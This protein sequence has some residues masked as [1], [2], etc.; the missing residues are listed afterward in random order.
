MDDTSGRARGDAA[1]EAAE[2]TAAVAAMLEDAAQKGWVP[3]ERDAVDYIAPEDARIVERVDGGHPWARYTARLK[4]G[5]LYQEGG[6]R[7]VLWTTEAAA[8]KLLQEKARAATREAR[9]FTLLE[10]WRLARAT[11]GVGLTV[12]A[13]L[14]SDDALRKALAD[15]IRARAADPDQAGTVR[16]SDHQEI[17]AELGVSDEDRR[18]LRADRSVTAAERAAAAGDEGSARNGDVLAAALAAARGRKDAVVLEGASAPFVGREDSAAEQVVERPGPEWSYAVVLKGGDLHFEGGLRRERHTTARTAEK[19]VAARV[20]ELL[21]ARDLRLLVWL[22]RQLSRARGDWAAEARIAADPKLRERLDEAIR[23]AAADYHA[24]PPL[25]VAQAR[26]LREAGVD[27]D[28]I[29]RLAAPDARAAVRSAAARAAAIARTAW[30][31]RT[32]TTVAAAVTER[33]AA[34]FRW[35]AEDVVA[36]VDPDDERITQR[37]AGRPDWCTHAVVLDDGSVHLEGGVVRQRLAPEDA[38]AG[39]FAAAAD[40]LLERGSL[41]ALLDLQAAIDASPRPRTLA[42]FVKGDAKRQKLLRA[43]AQA[44]AAEERYA[45]HVVRPVHGAALVALGVPVERVR[46]LTG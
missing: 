35:V 24:D 44:L 18:L 26:T 41:Y 45:G 21:G 36:Y 43:R 46:A 4:G 14:W 19:L 27:E 12:G 1:R 32:R 39:L 5:G 34:G 3:L 20:E 2:R 11:R 13:T 31:G 10:T 37:L 29:V 6:A 40:D 28:T 8:R 9:L 23:T 16:R 22:R 42:E 30:T 38:L 25:A 7:R 17:L 33:L 15:R